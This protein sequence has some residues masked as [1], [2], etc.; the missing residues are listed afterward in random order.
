MGFCSLKRLV[1]GYMVVLGLL[2]AEEVSAL[3]LRGIK[4]THDGRYKEA[5]HLFKQAHKQ[6]DLLGSA[7]L[8]EMYLFGDG[9]KEDACKAKHY[10]TLVIKKKPSQNGDVAVIMA[11]ALL[12]SMYSDGSCVKKDWDKT[13][14]LLTEVLEANGALIRLDGTNLY[15]NL[16]ELRAQDFGKF[17]LRGGM[18]G[19]SVDMMGQCLEFSPKFKA[20]KQALLIA[21]AC[22]EKALEFGL[23]ATKHLQRV[24]QKLQRQTPKQNPE[25]KIFL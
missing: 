22:Y 21:K 3:M 5:F 1:L 14:Q 7:Y 8:G 6:G 13:A 10:F 9:M 24:Q 12:S 2:R 4:A 23:D 25:V 18:V 20:S 17:S 11:K 16:D 15:V 19:A